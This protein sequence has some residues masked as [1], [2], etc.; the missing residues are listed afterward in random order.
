MDSLLNFITIDLLVFLQ[1]LVSAS[2]SFLGNVKVVVNLIFISFVLIGIVKVAKEFMDGE[3]SRAKVY[4]IG[5]VV[6]LFIFGI[7]VSNYDNITGF[8]FGMNS[9][10]R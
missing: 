3:T 8:L 5:Y 10:L 1:G 4:L 7:V 6:G 2:N 9:Q